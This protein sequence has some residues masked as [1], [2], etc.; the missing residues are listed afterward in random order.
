MGVVRSRLHKSL[1]GLLLAAVLLGLTEGALRLFVPMEALLLPGERPGGMLSVNDAGVLV[2]RAGMSGGEPDGPYRWRWTLDELALRES[3]PVDRR[4][5]DELR[6]LALGDSWVFGYSV[7]QGKTLPDRLEALLA[8]RLGRP[9]QVIN[10]GVFGS[11]AFDMLQRWRSLSTG[12][13]ID[14]VLLG[15]PHNTRRQE[16]Q[17]GE[18][19]HWYSQARIG[20]RWTGRLY[21]LVRRGLAAWTLPTYAPGT[22]DRADIQDLLTIVGDARRRGKQAWF[23]DFGA[24]PRWEPGGL[25]PADRVWRTPMG[26]AGVPVF[27]HTLDERACWGFVDRGHPSEAGAHA[28]ARVVAEGIAQGARPEAPVSEPRCSEVDGAGPGKAGW[29]W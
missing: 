10:A 3:G 16:R 19:Q 9:V 13:D 12:L 17:S 28:I 8:E 24:A 4:S 5:P 15:R 18:R 29:E 22:N 14:G 25:A 26:A 21:L 2:M 11:S 20:P 7:D 1:I 27:G 23:V 6:I